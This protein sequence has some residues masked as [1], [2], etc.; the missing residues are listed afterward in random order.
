MWD[1]TPGA[2]LAIR[3]ELSPRSKIQS[4]AVADSQM[5]Q[6][7]EPCIPRAG[8]GATNNFRCL[9]HDPLE[10]SMHLAHCRSHVVADLN[11]AVVALLE[12]DWVGADFKP[13]FSQRSDCEPPVT[14]A[15]TDL[16]VR[17]GEDKDVVVDLIIGIPPRVEE[18][19]QLGGDSSV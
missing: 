12:H 9:N 2:S 6:P 5:H 3:K 18:P 13:L 4:F 17:G 14:A 19:V 8:G 16:K 11:V 15:Q 7:E 1:E 10:P